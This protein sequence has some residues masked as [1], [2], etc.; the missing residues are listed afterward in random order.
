MASQEKSFY[1]LPM[2][3]EVGRYENCRVTRSSTD[4]I[5]TNEG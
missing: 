5:A 4:C 3:E 2:L 1:F